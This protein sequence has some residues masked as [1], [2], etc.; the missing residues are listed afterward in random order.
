MRGSE[1]EVFEG[2]TL[3]NLLK[4]IYNI[5]AER[6]KMISGLIAE[7]SKQVKSPQEAV[8]LAPIIKDLL[9]VGVKNDEQLTKV[10]TVVQRIISADAY[11]RNGGDPTE[12]LTEAEKEQILKNADK[13]LLAATKD[14][15]SDISK[16]PTPPVKN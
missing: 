1:T 15:A 3:S 12:V 2:K 10:A 9:E 11:Q 13:D 16:I 14:I 6:R 8:L 7:W 4:D 5:S